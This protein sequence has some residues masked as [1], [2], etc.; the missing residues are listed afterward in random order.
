MLTLAYASGVETDP[1]DSAPF[2]AEPD[3]AALARRIAAA[4]PG[5]AAAAEA[6]LYRR[7]APR[8]RLYG[9]KHL[10]ERQAAADLVQQVLLM[11]IERLRAGQVREPER[12]ASYVLGM[13]RMVVL[14]LQ[15]THARHERLL[16]TFA[17]DL[18]GEQSAIAPL[19]DDAS[20]LR[21]LGRLPERERSIL[22]MTF[23][24]DRQARDVAVDLG[25]SEGNVRVI[26]HRGLER[27]RQCMDSNEAAP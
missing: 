4:G 5:L 13:C 19:V 17:H 27:L 9:L 2:D 23:Y 1:N 8:V 6:E 11:T 25:I 12:L 7:L 24:D 16:G 21:C 22:V 18:H 26:R 20:L 10:R 14:D 3:D 15:R